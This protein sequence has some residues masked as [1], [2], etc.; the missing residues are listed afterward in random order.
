MAPPPP[1]PPEPEPLNPPTVISILTNNAQP[2]ILGTWP[3][4]NAKSLMVTLAERAFKLGEN[5]ELSSDGSGNWRLKP[6]APMA[7]GEYE[8]GVEV[9]DGAGRVAAIESP[10]KL[11]VDTVAPADPNVNA[12]T[13]QESPDRLAGTW[14][15]G[16]AVLLRISL[17]GRTYELGKSDH[18]ISDGNGSWSLTLPERLPEGRH[19]LSIDIAD[20]A[21]NTVS[22]VFANAIEVDSTPPAKP[23]IAHSRGTATPEKITGTW[24][25]GE[26]V[27]LA[28]ALAGD[29]Y[30][31][32]SSAALTS[33]GKGNWSL[34]LSSPMAPGRYDVVVETADRAGN[35]SRISA[36]GAIEIA[37][38]P[39][40]PTVNPVAGNNPRPLVTG[41]FDPDRTKRL[42]VTLGSKTYELGRDGALTV[43]EKGR[44]LLSAETLPDG[45][46]DVQ[47]SA[48]DEFGNVVMDGTAGEI[49]ID[50]TPPSPPTIDRKLTN[51][52]TPRIGGTWAEG[53]AVDL[54]VS[55][56]GKT[57]RHGG[58]PALTIEPAG[59]W[60]VAVEPL[61]DGYYDAV[62]VSAD[63]FGNQSR[64]ASVAE[65]VI[66][67]TPPAAPTVDRKGGNDPTPEITGTWPV[68][69]ASLFSVHIGGR[70]HVLGT[71]A[72]LTAGNDGSW[73]L[74]VSE[75]LRDGYYDVVAIVRDEAGNESRDS[76]V[77]ETVID[78]TPPAVPTVNAGSAFPITGSFLPG[79]TR[80]LTV[81]LADRTYELGK[82]PELTASEGGWSLAPATEL[83]PG[84]YDVV[85]TA[86]DEFGN[87]ST[88]ASTAE[89]YIAD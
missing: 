11:T 31:L 20:A 35:I 33:D 37:A 74:S 18:L 72:A 1:P 73:K 39:V 81:T 10:G 43:P 19:D 52:R 34:A 12:V 55:I 50:T 5:P 87:R 83:A 89:L 53:D 62:A 14:P 75:P 79:E 22:K 68:G 78:L 65:I 64:D 21:G 56:G 40:A 45:T 3:E 84:V 63:R 38:L 2:E 82:S 54:S 58:T 48:T 77:A 15:E 44:W 16:D 69:D 6:D 76:S 4:N 26:A 66:D 24:A 71:D 13:V 32:G 27:S 51:S 25:E 47:V 88:D 86:I 23:T 29:N 46:Y 60:S 30:K 9:S 7:D 67:T 28:V 70:T 61:A 41:T 36:P 80:T 57:Y 85:V 59:R 17:A 49:E 8:I 42:A